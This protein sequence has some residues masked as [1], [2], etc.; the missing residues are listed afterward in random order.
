MNLW[1]TESSLLIFFKIL[2]HMELL[3]KQKQNIKISKPNVD[4]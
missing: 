1:I 4:I 2:E 3:S